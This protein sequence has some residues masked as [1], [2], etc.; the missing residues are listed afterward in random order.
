LGSE[1]N[2]NVN[3]HWWPV[4]LQRY[5][6]DHNN[7]ISIVTSDGKIEKK[8][9]HRRKIGNKRRG[10]YVDMG[11]SPWS[12]TFEHIFDEVDDSIPYLINHLS[13]E[14]PA[15]GR[16]LRDWI[17]I[18][19]RRLRKKLET[20]DISN[21][22]ELPAEVEKKLLIFIFSILLRSPSFRAKSNALPVSM[23]LP[24]NPS[25]G[26]VTIWNRFCTVERQIKL[27]PPLGFFILFHSIKSEFIFG[28]GI[29][30]GITGTAGGQSIRGRCLVPLTPRL[31]LYYFTVG[32]RVGGTKIVAINAGAELVGHINSLTQIYSKEKLFY[33][34]AKPRI[35]DHFFKNLHLKL[36][37]HKDRWLSEFEDLAGNQ[38]KLQYSNPISF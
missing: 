4:G 1:K 17:D 7:D 36:R 34:Y 31:C 28:D 19:K 3:H 8:K 25:I 2:S 38:N 18:V 9:Y 13:K 32:S 33:R 30:D 24:E 5:W 10:H 26:A 20:K 27:R 37:Y 15:K 22:Y 12:Q 35:E 16:K 11:D 14:Y 6:A 23:G 29:L 21:F